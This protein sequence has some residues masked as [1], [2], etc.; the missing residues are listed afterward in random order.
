MLHFAYV[1]DK[2]KR[3]YFTGNGFNSDI[4]LREKNTTKTALAKRIK[5]FILKFPSHKRLKIH[6][7]TLKGSHKKKAVR[8]KNPHPRNINYKIKEA[9]ENFE[10]FTGHTPEFIDKNDL[11][12]FD[13][14]FKVG[15]CDGVLYTTVRDGRTEQYIHK[16][17]Q[18]ARPILASNYDGSFIALLGGHYKFTE[19]GIVDD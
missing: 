1:L 11:P 19:R 10:K 9:I 16:F 14:G 12:K 8:K 17:K 18:R 2:G 5:T 13:V 4:V 15:M 3:Y 6:Y 7:G